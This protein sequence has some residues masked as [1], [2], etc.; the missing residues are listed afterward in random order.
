MTTRLEQR[1]SKLEGRTGDDAPLD[2]TIT[3]VSP[4]GTPP[5]RCRLTP[6]GLVAIDDEQEADDVVVD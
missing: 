1:L 2:F 4:D 3:L 6:A 5:R